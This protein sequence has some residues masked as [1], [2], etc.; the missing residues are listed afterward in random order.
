MMIYRWDETTPPSN[1]SN[2]NT[3]LKIFFVK[4]QLHRC[5]R[6]KLMDSFHYFICGNECFTC[7]LKKYEENRAGF[8]S[9]Q[10]VRPLTCNLVM[11]KTIKFPFNHDVFCYTAAFYYGAESVTKEARHKDR[12]KRFFIAYFDLPEEYV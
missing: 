7:R 6:K 2:F 1:N 5:E 4:N 11:L 9:L 10:N 3:L 12:P 8:Q